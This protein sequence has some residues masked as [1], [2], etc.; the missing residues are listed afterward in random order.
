MRFGKSSG[1][2]GIYTES[3]NIPDN[4][5]VTAGLIVGPLM[6]FLKI[7]CITYSIWL[8][9]HQMLKRNQHNQVLG[10]RNRLLLS[11]YFQNNG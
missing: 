2:S 4:F 6:K 1:T 5:S 7:R 8:T 10:L 9:N 3:D 11:K